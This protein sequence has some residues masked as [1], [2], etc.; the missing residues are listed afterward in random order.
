MATLTT[1]ANPDTCIVMDMYNKLKAKPTL[2][3]CTTT[4]AKTFI[5]LLTLRATAKRSGKPLF[6]TAPLEELYNR[7]QII[8]D[9]ATKDHTIGSRNLRWEMRTMPKIF[10]PEAEKLVKDFE[11]IWASGS[12][13][14]QS[15]PADPTLKLDITRVNHK[16]RYV[17]S[18]A[19]FR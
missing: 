7:I 3:S 4:P 15:T 11:G 2:E 10:E 18:E 12:E 13:H 14:V 9:E 19:L 17:S 8:V 5:E 6:P 1:I 16:Q